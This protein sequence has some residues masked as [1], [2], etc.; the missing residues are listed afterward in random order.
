MRVLFGLVLVG[1]GM[2]LTG[3]V[4]N[5]LDALSNGCSTTLTGVN[6]APPPTTG[7]TGTAPTVV[8][9]TTT[10]GTTTTTAPTVNTGNTNNLTTGDTTIA[11]EGS[12][13]ITTLGN[14]ALSKLLDSPLNHVGI[15]EAANQQ[16]WFDTK[17]PS[18]PNWPVS[19]M[20]TYNEY[21]TCINDNGTFPGTPSISKAQGQGK[22][23]DVTDPINPVPGTGGHGLGA[24]YKLYRYYQPGGYDEELQ[25]WTW[26]NSYATQ[27]R[28]VTVSQTDPQHQ[29]WSFGGNYTTAANMPTSGQVVYNG[30]W[31]A[32]A[33]TSGF[34]DNL[35]S[36]KSNDPATVGQTMS[37]N[38]SWRVTGT[39]NLKV[40]FGANK[41]K[42]TLTSDF[43]QGVNKDTGYTTVNIAAAKSFLNQCNAGAQVCNPQSSSFDR[44]NY[45]NLSNYE[46]DYM[47]SDILL[48]GAITTSAKNATK[49]NQVAGTASEDPSK[50]WTT[51][52]K[53]PM[54][55]GF[56]GPSAKEVTGAFAFDATIAGPNGGVL[57][58][59][60][61]RRAY[62]Q[63][64]GIFNGTAP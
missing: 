33:K 24:D 53:N 15:N 25:V 27:Y 6:C 50:G 41:F 59:N 16:I 56:F 37:Y 1:T 32:T 45:N 22:C 34:L 5:T 42:G 28:D 40:D 48:D 29:A 14:P 60:N 13:T 49:Q 61:D 7:S 35:V 17:T 47:N 19:K 8:T 46:S 11:L 21:G 30:Q 58:I 62:V 2:A 63:M 55:A 36:G 44:T 38:N 23:T 26:K 4:S 39:S 43:W 64:S 54:F 9:T 57:P 31:G 12:A 18:N 10:T 3:C 52:A 51:S 20:F